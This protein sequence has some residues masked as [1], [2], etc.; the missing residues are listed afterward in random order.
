MPN[1]P[2]TITRKRVVIA[3]VVLF[4]LFVLQ[5]A[6]LGCQQAKT[7]SVVNE[8]GK[9]RVLRTRDVDST[10]REL[11][12]SQN[13]QT[14]AIRETVVASPKQSI[15]ILK[16]LGYNKGQIAAYLKSA[17]ASNKETLKK[18]RLIGADKK[19]PKGN[20]FSLPI[21]RRNYANLFPHD[22]SVFP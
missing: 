9:F 11:C 16:A 10:A 21:L 20:C 14:L 7:R 4:A 19:H 22:E 12:R 18:F 13:Q 3:F 1:Q 15:P 2:V 8:Q 5:G 17:R 6:L